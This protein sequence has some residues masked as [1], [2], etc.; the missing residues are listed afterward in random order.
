[1]ELQLLFEA[2]A[3]SFHSKYYACTMRSRCTVHAVVLSLLPTIPMIWNIYSRVAFMF[4][5]CNANESHTHTHTSWNELMI[6]FDRVISQWHSTVC[7]RWRWWWQSRCWCPF[8]AAAPIQS[9]TI[10]QNDTFLLKIIIVVSLSDKQ[11]AFII[12]WIIETH[13][14]KQYR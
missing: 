5:M 7:D 14:W 11:T 6:A 12:W 8:A 9:T 13:T 2:R 3:T 4:N 1:M 10:H